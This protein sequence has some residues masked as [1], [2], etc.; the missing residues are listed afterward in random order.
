MYDPG[1]KHAASLQKHAQDQHYLG[2]IRD[3]LTISMKYCKLGS[4]LYT[5]LTPPLATSNAGIM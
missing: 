4:V 2:V 3:V 5:D 1:A